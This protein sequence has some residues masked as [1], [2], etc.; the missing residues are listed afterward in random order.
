MEAVNGKEGVG[1]E[2]F[3]A[4][5]DPF[6]PIPVD[7]KK[8]SQGVR[9]ECLYKESLK[10]LPEMASSLMVEMV[11]LL[12]ARPFTVQFPVLVDSRNLFLFALSALFLTLQVQPVHLDKQNTV[13]QFRFFRDQLNP[14]QLLP[15]LS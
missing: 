2:I 8:V 6:R 12:Q 3:P 11:L 9:I 5:H 14:K 15:D 13:G 10:V 7:N 4:G 1:W